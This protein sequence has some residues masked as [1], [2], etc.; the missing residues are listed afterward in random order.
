MLL[1]VAIVAASLTLFSPYGPEGMIGAAFLSLGVGGLTLFATAKHWGKILRT[2]AFAVFG[3]LIGS[4]FR[5]LGAY[6]SVAAH[7]IPVAL[8]IL[9]SVAFGSL[10]YR[11]RQTESDNAG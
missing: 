8:G 7:A 2:F 3:F 10:A 9:G 6:D 4:M 5:P 1:A 11:D